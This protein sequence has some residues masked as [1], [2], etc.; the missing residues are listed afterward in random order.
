M[1][2][3]IPDYKIFQDPNQPS[4]RPIKKIFINF[5]KDIAHKMFGYKVRF[6]DEK[7]VTYNGTGIPNSRALQTHKPIHF[8]QKDRITDLVSRYHKIDGYHSK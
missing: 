5:D 1:G 3:S 7:Q 8:Y 6:T 2:G 4:Q